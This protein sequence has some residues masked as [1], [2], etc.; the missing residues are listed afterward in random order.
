MFDEYLLSQPTLLEK[1]PVLCGHGEYFAQISFYDSYDY[2]DNMMIISI[3]S[4]SS[5]SLFYC[6]NCIVDNEQTCSSRVSYHI[7]SMAVFG[8]YCRSTIVGDTFESDI[9]A[10]VYDTK[11]GQEEDFS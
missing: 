3:H 9:F 5:M 6:H 2:Y 8:A 11:Q 10:F 1:T 7:V 4:I